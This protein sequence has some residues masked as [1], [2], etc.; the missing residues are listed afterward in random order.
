MYVFLFSIEKKMERQRS[1]VPLDTLYILSVKSFCSS[2]DTANNYLKDLSSITCLLQT[3]PKCI[4]RDVRLEFKRKWMNEK[5]VNPNCDISKGFDYYWNFYFLTHKDF[6]TL[7][8]VKEFK[9]PYS[10]WPYY[11]DRL[12]VYFN[13]YVHRLN[14]STESL[15]YCRSCFLDI[16]KPTTFTDVTHLNF[17]YQTFWN[18]RN[19]NFFLI[20]KHLVSFS[21]EFLLNVVQNPDSWCSNCV[22]CPLFDYGN[23]R[24]C[25]ENTTYHNFEASNS[26]N[27]A[28]EAATL[29]FCK[30]Y[31]LYNPYKI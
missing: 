7:Q 12:H 16:C 29:Y 5:V 1:C 30:T 25:V 26:S 21:Q 14:D 23:L 22:L 17:D 24:K 8:N 4:E 3:I 6:V 31:K 18:E 20:T 10:D 28:S 9:N 27:D 2:L 19:W 13:Y 11:N 15:I